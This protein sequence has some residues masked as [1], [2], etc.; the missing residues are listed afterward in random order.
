MRLKRKAIIGFLTFGALASPVTAVTAEEVRLYNW[1]GYIEPSVIEQYQAT[2]GTELILDAYE[3][4]DEAEARL[5][6]HG[7]GYDVAIVPAEMVGRLI[8]AGAIQRYELDSEGSDKQLLNIFF[9]AMPEA[10]GY[11]LP[12]LWGTTGLVYDFDAVIERLP[13]APLDS[14]ALLFDPAYAKELA[15]CGITIVDSVEEMVPAALSYLGLDPHSSV[16]E[17]LDAAFEILTT[18]APYVRSFDTVQYDDVLDGN[19]CLAAAWSTDGLAAFEEQ[20]STRYRYIVPKEGT[21]LWA[22]VLVIPKDTE[23]L[24]SA[25]KLVDFILEPEMISL[26]ASYSN[27]FAS[28]P[29]ARSESDTP[30]FGLWPQGFS[31]NSLNQLYF[32]KPL[33]GK[34]KRTLNRRWR[35]LKSGF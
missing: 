33:N 27:A 25:L 6:A 5:S 3:R 24:E 30:D 13:D 19:I 29:A 14:W 28:L 2:A 17:D 26:S 31:E 16:P 4:A 23:K 12:Y 35:F 10:E 18:I 34:E 9:E 20:Q 21:N 22:D 8:S 1:S 7:T 32:I 15:D 11:A